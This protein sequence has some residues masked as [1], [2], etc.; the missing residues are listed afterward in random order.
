MRERILDPSGRLHGVWH[1]L[2]YRRCWEEGSLLKT[3]SNTLNCRAT[4]LLLLGRKYQLLVLHAPLHCMD[5]LEGAKNIQTING[6]QL[7]LGELCKFNT[8]HIYL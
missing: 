8:K 1:C 3:V 7:L 6:I 2:N 4:R 5:M